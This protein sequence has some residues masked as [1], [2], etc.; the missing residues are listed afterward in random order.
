MPRQVMV[1][2]M[3]V[4]KVK[5][6]LKWRGEDTVQPLPVAFTFALVSVPLDLS[7]KLLL[8]GL[9]DPAVVVHPR[10]ADE[11][12]VNPPAGMLKAIWSHGLVLHG[13]VDC[14]SVA[15]SP[16]SVLVTDHE[17]LAVMVSVPPRL[18]VHPLKAGPLVMSAVRPESRVLASIV[19]LVHV[20][21]TERPLIFSVILKL[22]KVMMKGVSIG[23][24]LSSVSPAAS[25]GAATSVTAA[26]A[27]VTAAILL[28]FRN[29][30]RICSL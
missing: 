14:G 21:V 3:A 20:T 5:V 28:A 29:M 18:S 25:A 1:S 22:L 23:L 9:D 12:N 27:V 8:V 15:G 19:T 2:E 30:I 10:K 17:P 7:S 4:L 11:V 16:V 13:S 6:A 24:R 26:T